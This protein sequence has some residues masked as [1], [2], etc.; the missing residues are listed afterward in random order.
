MPCTVTAQRENA[1][2][3]R[4]GRC[5]T[6]SGYS[7]RTIR[8]THEKAAREWL[9]IMETKLTRI[10]RSVSNRS[11]R[12]EA[13][14]QQPRGC[15]SAYMIYYMSHFAPEHAALQ[16]GKF[17]AAMLTRSCGMTGFR[18]YLISLEN[19]RL[20]LDLSWQYRV[21]ASALAIKTAGAM[22]DSEVQSSLITSAGRAHRVLHTIGH[23]PGV[24]R[25]TRLATD[26]LASSI[27]LSGSTTRT[28][29]NQTAL[30]A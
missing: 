15:S 30:A 18:E 2:V 4:S 6:P 7:T 10:D 9:Y 23:I 27:Y 21:A 11:A 16:W 20:I 26:L 25:L 14:L 24:D 17:K 22:G 1:V 29:I 12:G 28:R 8:Q 3:C 19:G 5:S 13:L